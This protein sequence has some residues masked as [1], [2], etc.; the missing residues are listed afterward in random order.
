MIVERFLTWA[1]SAPA[2]LRARAGAALARAYLSDRFEG[3]ERNDAE[4]AL[5]VLVDD[6]EAEVRSAI[7]S[8]LCAS[9]LAPRHVIAALASDKPEISMPV[10]A[11][12]PVFIDAEL[13][14][15][16]ATGSAAQQIAIAWRRPVSA[17]VSAAIA[18]IGELEAVV[19][20]LMND[21][22]II[23]PR[24]LHRIAERHLEAEE[25]QKKLATRGDLLPQ[26]WLLLIEKASECLRDRYAAKKW[27]PDCRID[28]MVGEQFDKAVIAFAAGMDRSSQHLLVAELVRTERMSAAFLLRAVCMGNI[29]MFSC[30]LAL[31]GSVPAERAEA[32]L[33]S[34]PGNALRALYRQ[35]GL[36]MVAYTVFADLIA[37]WRK[38][39]AETREGEMGKLPCLVTRQVLENY[40]N[41][42]D[43][44][45]D[46]LLVL[47][48]GI[49]AENERDSARS[50][51]NRIIERARNRA[52]ASLAPP[53]Q[54]QASATT[55]GQAPEIELPEEF[56]AD[57]ARHLAEEI[58]DL[59]EAIVS[60][61]QSVGETDNA[62][63]VSHHSK[64][65]FDAPPVM[66]DDPGEPANDDQ[67]KRPER[68]YPD[69]FPRRARPAGRQVRAA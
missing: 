37:A 4:A 5:T 12:S 23:P 17:A 40:R 33:E 51:I 25:V 8:V 43:R 3:D 30:A 21:G 49:A 52:Q 62:A 58:L 29:S 66:P 22:A 63:P 45:L 38:A 27:L 42:T 46:N 65:R 2:H 64:T 31:L 7:A 55:G 13:V 50:E 35:A 47:L 10:L 67:P 36:P 48:R 15:I 26:T 41:V 18:E 60:E 69:G 56:L 6:N 16:A 11:R 54:E 61:Q 68:A 9:N 19:A 59:E 1:E 39:L 53:Q 34:R 32:I 20:L 57:F 24:F 44:E 14:D 28:A